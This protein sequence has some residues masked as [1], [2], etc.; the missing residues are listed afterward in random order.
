MRLFH[1]FIVQLL[2]LFGISLILL[3]LQQ[4]VHGV[5]AGHIGQKPEGV[6]Q[7]IQQPGIGKRHGQTH[8]SE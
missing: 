8:L 3:L 7:H 6:G 5:A 1:V 4:I 2:I